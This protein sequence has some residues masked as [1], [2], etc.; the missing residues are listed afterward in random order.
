MFGQGDV[1]LELRRF[2]TVPLNAFIELKPYMPIA[3]SAI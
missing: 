3:G 2:P 1:C